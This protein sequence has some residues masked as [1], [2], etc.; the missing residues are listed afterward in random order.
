MPG[1]GIWSKPKPHEK[2]RCLIKDKPYTWHEARKRWFPDKTNTV[3]PAAPAAHIATP[4]PDVAPSAPAPGST[5]NKQHMIQLAC[6]N[7]AKTV[8][9]AI[10]SLAEQFGEE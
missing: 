2:N 4:T 10:A 9:A 8:N 5:P 7:T 1:T 3:P 6:A